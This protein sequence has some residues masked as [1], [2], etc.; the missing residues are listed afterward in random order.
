MAK[1]QT[2]TFRDELRAMKPGETR[3]FNRGGAMEI[4]SART[5]A[6]QVAALDGRKYATRADFTSKT[7]AITRVH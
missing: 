3:I 1:E 2:Q 7:I 5:A 4:Y 6:A